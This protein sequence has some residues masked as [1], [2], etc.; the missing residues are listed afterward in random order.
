MYHFI[1]RYLSRSNETEDR[2]M[3]AMKKKSPN[4]ETMNRPDT[5]ETFSGSGVV[6]QGADSRDLSVDEDVAFLKG[7]VTF[8]KGEVIKLTSRT[9]RIEHVIDT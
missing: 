4:D 3:T 6:D 5:P 9:D 1:I 8:L 7:E 2:K